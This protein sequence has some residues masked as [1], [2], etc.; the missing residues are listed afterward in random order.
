M[1][2]GTCLKWYIEKGETPFD[3]IARLATMAGQNGFTSYALHCRTCDQPFKENYECGCSKP[4]TKTET[5]VTN[6]TSVR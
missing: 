3:A 2:H 4:E 5:I 1:S 6:V